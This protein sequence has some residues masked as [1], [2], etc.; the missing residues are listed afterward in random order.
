MRGLKHVAKALAAAG[1]LVVEWQ[2]SF[3]YETTDKMIGDFWFAD[4]GESSEYPS[5]IMIS[6]QGCSQKSPPS[7]WGA[8]V[9]GCRC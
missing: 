8:S 2:G 6:A 9:L 7:F 5:L 4:G 1:H 3:R